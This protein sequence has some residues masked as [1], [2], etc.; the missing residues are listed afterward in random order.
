[1]IL[2]LEWFDRPLLLSAVVLE[3]Y[4][5][6]HQSLQYPRFSSTGKFNNS[7]G[8]DYYFLLGAQ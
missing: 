2:E 7:L 6:N 1:M 4:L 8:V 5:S 3:Q